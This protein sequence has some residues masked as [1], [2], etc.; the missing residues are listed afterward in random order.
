M[1]RARLLR[2]IPLFLVL[3]TLAICSEAAQ[4]EASSD[5]IQLKFN[6]DEAEAVLAILDKRAA[7]TA[8]TDSDWQR[9]FATEPYIRL[10]KR[11]AAMH[12]DFNDDDFKTFVLSPGLAEKASAPAKDAGC[13]GA[14]RSRRLSTPRSGLPSGTSR[15]QSQS[16]R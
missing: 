13:V 4:P 12:R 6:T 14:R 16:L 8:V 2:I 1:L 10:Q 11:E 7:G 3:T 15:H 5:R 9:L